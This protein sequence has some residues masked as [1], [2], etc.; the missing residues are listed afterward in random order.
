M[1]ESTEWTGPPIAVIGMGMDAGALG[2]A[3]LTALD[4]AELLI[5]ASTHL[6]AFPEITAEKHPYPSPMSGLWDVL[7][8]HAGRRIALLASVVTRVPA[9][10]LLAFHATVKI[11]YTSRAIAATLTAS[12]RYPPS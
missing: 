2:Q 12:V 5:G 7:R 11:S 9:G 8:A 10:T 6:A 4:R 3:A 1:T